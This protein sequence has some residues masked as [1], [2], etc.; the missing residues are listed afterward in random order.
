MPDNLGARMW[1]H[2]MVYDHLFCDFTKPSNVPGAYNFRC[3]NWQ[4][5]KGPCENSSAAPSPSNRHHL[6]I[7]VLQVH[8]GQPQNNLNH[9]RRAPTIKVL[10]MRLWGPFKTFYGTSSSTITATDYLQILLSV[11]IHSTSP[12]SFINYLVS[13]LFKAYLLYMSTFLRF[14]TLLFHFPS[15][16]ST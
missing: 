8:Q 5:L 13:I 2:S 3:P 14:P 15:G 9:P 7:P 4:T 10:M 11:N 1:I 16:M 12:I 6:H